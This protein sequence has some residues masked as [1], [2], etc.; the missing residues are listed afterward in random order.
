MSSSKSIDGHDRRDRSISILRQ[1]IRPSKIPN[2]KNRPVRSIPRTQD[3]IRFALLEAPQTL[4]PQVLRWMNIR[5]VFRRVS[6][7]STDRIG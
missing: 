6:H 7:V 4:Q 2:S 3:D 1:D 5:F